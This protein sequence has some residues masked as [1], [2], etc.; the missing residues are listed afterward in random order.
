MK[1]L[2]YGMSGLHGGVESFIY[3]Y[4]QNFSNDLQIDYI[5]DFSEIPFED[6]FISKGSKIFHLP[7]RK[8]NYFNYLKEVNSI[9]ENNK[10]DAV[11]ANVCTLSSIEIMKTAQKHNVDKVIV[12]S[13]NSQNMGGKVTKMLHAFNKKQLNRYVTDYWACSPEAGKWMFDGICNTDE[14][15]VI[16]NAIDSNLYVYN[17]EVRNMKRKELGLT[18]EFVIGHVGRFHFQKNHSFLVDIFNEIQKKESNSKL[19]LIGS[20]PLEEEIKNKIQ[21]LH[22]EDK[23][24]FLG[25]RSDVQ[26]LM[27]AMDTFLLPSNFEGLPFVLVEAQAAG[28]PAFTSKDVVSSEAKITDLLTYIDLSKSASYWADAVLESKEIDRKDRRGDISQAGFDI[29]TEARKVEDN[30]K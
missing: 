16:N 12:H 14:I 28:L 11:W 26:Q 5:T 19:L 25:Q 21:D 20:G 4:T 2:I 24:L 23:V 10:Y 6:E 9:F 22:L 29:A 1:I 7:S 13:H 30:F 27:Q 8:K 17:Q 18:N 3:N 15:T